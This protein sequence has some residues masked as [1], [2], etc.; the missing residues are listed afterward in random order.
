MVPRPSLRNIAHSAAALAG[1]TG[2]IGFMALMGVF[3]LVSCWTSQS[4][5]GEATSSGE[6]TTTTSEVT[7]GCGAGIDY[8]LSSAGGN[9]PVLFFWA[10]VLIG[11]VAL[12]ASAA[13]TG[14]R[15]ITWVTALVGAVISVIGLMSIGWYFI[16]PTLFLL[17]AALSLTIDAHRSAGRSPSAEI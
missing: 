4:G 17:A 11:L 8:L 7:R 13:W 10:V 12:G 1:L 9:A 16:L 5:S 15:R 3:G 2:A 14:H 6:V